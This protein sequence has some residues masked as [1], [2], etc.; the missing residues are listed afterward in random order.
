MGLRHNEKRKV[1][2]LLL[3]GI[4]CPQPT[5]SSFLPVYNATR[6][7]KPNST[8][9]SMSSRTPPAMPLKPMR[10][11]SASSRNSVRWASRPFK[12]GRS[13][14]SSAGASVL[15]LPEQSAGASG[16]SRS[17]SRRVANRLGRDRERQPVGDPGAAQAQWGRVERGKCRSDA[18]VTGAESQW[19]MGNLLE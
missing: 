18:S 9:S 5:R 6:N 19:A 11:N 10:P 4:P 17:N 16:L 8:P 12:P 13:A 15:A 3:G 14:S 7:G 1:Y 2:S